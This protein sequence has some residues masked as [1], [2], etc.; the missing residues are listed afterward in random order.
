MIPMR[1]GEES[2]FHDWSGPS[3]KNARKIGATSVPPGQIAS[4]S[5]LTTV[6]APPATR[7]NALSEL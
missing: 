6:G 3:V 4:R 5:A 2:L 1:E 7:P